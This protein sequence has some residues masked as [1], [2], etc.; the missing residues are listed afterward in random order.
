MFRT[1]QLCGCAVLAFGIGLL[2]G[3]WVESAFWGH[4]FCIG[5]LLIGGNLLCRR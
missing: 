1:N 4:C 2:I 5:F 3:L